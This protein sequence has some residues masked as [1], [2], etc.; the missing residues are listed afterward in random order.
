MC[1]DRPLL[2]RT[3]SK[4][5]PFGDLDEG[6]HGLQELRSYYDLFRLKAEAVRQT[7][8]RSAWFSEARK[9]DDQLSTQLGILGH[10]HSEIHDKAF[11]H[12][13]HEYI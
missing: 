11:R 2:S 8:K 7:R 5:V 10:L 1:S 12:V 13:L 3:G 6:T 9:L 4:R